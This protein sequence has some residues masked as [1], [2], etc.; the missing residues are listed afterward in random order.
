MNEI[1]EII[2]IWII[3]A[4]LLLGAGY[5]LF[6]DTARDLAEAGSGRMAIVPAT[7]PIAADCG[8]ANSIANDAC[9]VQVQE[10]DTLAMIGLYVLVIIVGM[11][12]FGTIVFAIGCVTQ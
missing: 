6:G 9:N 11:T 4:V 1:N 5:A 8:Q 10:Y 2:V 3:C 12:G 7:T